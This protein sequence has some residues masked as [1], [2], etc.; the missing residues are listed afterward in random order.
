MKCLKLSVH[1]TPRYSHEYEGHEFIDAFSQ[2]FGFA[3]D[4]TTKFPREAVN[5]LYFVCQKAK[6]EELKVHVSVG[7]SVSIAI[8]VS[9]L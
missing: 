7:L 4:S 2:L 1:D 9:S 3:G 6:E 5:V 8:I